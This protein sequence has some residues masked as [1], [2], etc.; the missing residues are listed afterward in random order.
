MRFEA[1]KLAPVKEEG[2]E[3]SKLKRGAKLRIV[4]KLGMHI[5]RQ[6]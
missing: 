4:S 5:Q 1:D 3:A 2:R 6:V